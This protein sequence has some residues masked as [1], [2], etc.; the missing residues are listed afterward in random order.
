MEPFKPSRQCSDCLMGLA[1]QAAA[2]ARGDDSSFLLQTEAVAREILAEAEQKGL[3]SPDVGNRIL[4]EVRIRSGVSDPYVEFKARE[5]AQ[6][7]KILSHM[8]G[9]LSDDLRSCVNLAALGNSID[10]FTD[11]EQTLSEIPNQ[12][13][14][15]AFFFHDDID[16][17]EGFLSAS[18][19]LVLY[20]TDNAGEIYFD[21]PLYEYI[22]KRAGRT[23]LVVKGGPSLNDL[24]RAELRADELEERF[25]E[26]ADTGTD[27]V[28]IDWGR[29]SKEFLDL[30]DQADLI[31]AK[32]MANFES[33]YPR[34]LSCPV[35]FLFKVKCQPMQDYLEAP[36]ESYW[37]LWKE[38]RQEGKSP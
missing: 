8:K 1:R 9:T 12:I 28:G 7:R 6:A 22:Q 10:F 4:R 26:V 15:G 14:K 30:V 32:G 23:V 13:Q 36:G 24:T 19:G 20:L 11:P 18:P 37:A 21:Q 38:A 5:M 2:Q 34:E 33:M 17:L 31:L 35:F 3:T 29:V 16:R 25:N 27:G